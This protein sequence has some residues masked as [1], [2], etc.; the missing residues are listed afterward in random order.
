[1][2]SARSSPGRLERLRARMAARGRRGLLRRQARA[3]ALADRVHPRRRRGEGGRALRPAAG[4][5]R[6]RRA[7]HRFPVHDPGAP[8]GARRGGRRDRLRPRGR[9]AARWWI[10]PGPGA[11]AVEAGAVS[12]AL[13]E[14]LAAAAPRRGAGGGRR[15]DRGDAGR[16]EPR[17]GRAD[18]GGL[19]GGRPG[20][21][22]AAAGDPGRRDGARPGAAPRVA[23][24]NRRR[25]GPGVRRR[26][27]GRPRGGAAARVARRP[28]RPLGRRP[29]V[30]LRGPGRGLP[31]RH[32][33]DAVRGR[34]GG[35][36]PCRLRPRAASPAGADRR[37]AGTWSRT[38]P[39]R[40]VG[41]WTRS[42]GG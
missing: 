2:P 41:P 19:R 40:T 18:R 32:D 4:R 1:M 7:R 20:A 17:R 39:R 28:A 29:P 30:R 11:S 8:R 15:L 5:A 24:A 42:P 13:W 36:R 3:H 38:A 6:G 23:D 35:P 9:L 12:H 33:P 25:G 34:A 27:P 31:Q 10:G 14:R 37:A 22:G 26:L 21:G 16:Q